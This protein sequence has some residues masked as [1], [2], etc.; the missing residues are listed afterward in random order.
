M[1]RKDIP[2]KNLKSKILIPKIWMVWMYLRWISGVKTETNDPRD[3]GSPK[4]RM[5]VEPKYY[6]FRR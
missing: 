2:K 5:V 3:P 1:F 6:A 4:L